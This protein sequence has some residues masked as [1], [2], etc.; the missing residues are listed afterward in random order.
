MKKIAAILA[1]LP[2]LA[3]SDTGPQF[4]VGL[5]TQYGGLAGFKFSLN[6]D[7]SKVYAGAG[8]AETGGSLGNE[9]GFSVGW[10]KELN[11]NHALG[12][13]ARTKRPEDNEVTWS[14]APGGV[15]KIRYESFIGVNYTYYFNGT[16]EHGFLTGLT[17]GKSYI[18]SNY[19]QEFQS[20]MDYGVHFG[21]QF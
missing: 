20:G 11:D 14:P 7:S 12:L 3:L 6:M 9:Y 15:Y 1:I 8:L 16:D 13:V 17:A 21:Y 10:E 4:G 2:S 18:N 5:G 19:E